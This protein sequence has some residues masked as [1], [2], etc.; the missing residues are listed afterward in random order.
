VNSK[1]RETKK[2]LREK[3]VTDKAQWYI[4]CTAAAG[5]T[6]LA[7]ALHRWASPN[8][9][10]YLSY[11]LLA[12][13]ASTLKVR[14]PRMTGT[15]SVIFLFILIGIADC[16]FSETVTIGC[17]AA[18]MQVLWRPKRRP[19]STQAVFS[20]A[21]MAI[22]IGVSYWLSHMILAAARTNSLA[23]LLTLA[24]CLF[25]AINTALVATVISLTEGMPFKQV[26]LQWYLWAFP[27]Y[28][29]G[30]AIAGL[31][32][33]SNR[34]VGWQVSLLALPLMYL[35]YACYRQF[36]VQATQKLT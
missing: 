26:W 14:L 16:T 2:G 24:A 31:I 23:I 17:A 36:V 19:T 27:Y 10:R 20:V 13:L 6:L 22:S 32:S 3:G 29:V 18:L 7:A 30:A 33:Y 9:P 5:F 15:F 8:H 28:L 21:S 35:I 34:S 12:V 11:L 1:Q 4:D 25:F